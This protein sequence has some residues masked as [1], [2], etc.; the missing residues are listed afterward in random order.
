MLSQSIEV[1]EVDSLL[2]YRRLCD[3]MSD[4]SRVAFGKIE[5]ILSTEM[6]E[7]RESPE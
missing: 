7:I 5:S 3:V 4:L 2:I 1:K 6:N